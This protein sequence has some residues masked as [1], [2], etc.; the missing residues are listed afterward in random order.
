ML[1]TALLLALTLAPALSYAKV[2]KCPQPGGGF[3]YR[4]FP[5][6]GEGSGELKVVDPTVSTRA[7]AEPDRADAGDLVGDWC[8]FAVSTEIDSEKALDNIHWYFGSDYITYVHSRAWKP[9]GMEPPKYPVR[10][11]GRFFHVNDPMFGGDEAGWEVIGRREGV[12]LIEG[13]YGGILHM[14]PGRC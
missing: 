14:R 7:A 10:R 5:C 4:Q 6:D 1:R 13:P 12:I 2:F 9:V 11:A 3:E 8:E